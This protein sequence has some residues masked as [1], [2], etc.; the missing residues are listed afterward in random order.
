[1][2]LVAIAA[3]LLAALCPQ[4]E[5]VEARISLM[6][7]SDSALEA[8]NDVFRSALVAGEDDVDSTETGRA[9]LMGIFPPNARVQ[10]QTDQR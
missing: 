6:T 8:V 10:I 5:R 3:M 9:L 7:A 2:R 1:M 4:V